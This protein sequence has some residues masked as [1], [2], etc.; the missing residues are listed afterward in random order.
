MKRQIRKVGVLGSGVMG[1]GIAGHLAG[2]GLE[3]VMLDIVPPKLSEEDEK[4]GITKD[5]PDFRNRFA[6]GALARALRENPQSGPLLHSDDAELIS[7]G[8]FEDHAFRL[9]EC[10]WIIEVVVEDLKIKRT[11]MKVV[12]KNWNKKAVVSTN[13]SGIPLREIAE[14][15]KP[16]LKKV[17]LG[18][19]FFNPVRFMHLLEIIPF[20]ETDRKVVEFMAGFCETRLG[21]GVVFGKD[22]PNFVANRIGVAGM[23]GTMNLMMEQGMKIDE[24]DQ[25]FG[26]PLG[27]P[28]SALF[29]TAD[30][31]GLD[32]LVHIAHNTTSYVK[33]EE[34]RKY[35]TLP[36]WVEGM[37]EKKYLGNKTGSGFYKRVDKKTFKV[38][39]PETLEYGD[40]SGEKFQSLALSGFIP[41]V[42]ER[43]K[44]VVNGEGREAEFAKKAV[45]DQLLYAAE[46]IP[47][48]ADRVVEVDNAMKWGF[49]FEVGPFEAWDALG[50]RESV[51]DMEEMGFKVPKK[52]KDMLSARAR[53]FYKDKKGKKLY[54]DF[55]KKDYVELEESGLVVNLAD[56][57]KDPKRVVDSR[58]TA[59]IVDIGDGVYCVEFHSV[60][61]ALDQDM[62]EMMRKAV[63]LAE[64]KGRGVVIGNQAPGMPGA[65]SAGANIAV[66]LEGARSK[67]WDTI[68]EAVRYFQE[69]NTYMTY[70]PVPVVAA[71]FGLTLGGGAEVAMSCNKIVCHHDLFMGLVEVG[72]G[73]IPGGGGCMLM[74]RHYQNFLPRNASINDLQPF[75]T[76]L[77]R[78][79]GTATV[80]NSAAHARDLGFLRPFDKIAFNRRHLIGLAKKEVLAMADLGFVPPRPQKYQVMG[81]QLRGVANA[82]VQDLV[83]GGYATEYDAFILRKLAHI[84]GG[85]FV[86]ENAWVPEEHLLELERE[87]FVELCAQE[88]TQARLEHM[89]KT[90][91]ALR[92]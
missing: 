55:K 17:F 46:R 83:L 51:A 40:P 16:E 10:D 15:V 30:M 38:I 66:I 43:I 31:V 29:R 36:K 54:Y 88:K 71:P 28:K 33:P 32:T 23:I 4:K 37:T 41:D 34:A 52:I 87:A 11:V 27:R 79:I 69:T 90:G 77:L 74:L 2:A 86:A 47:E 67:Q 49:N 45:Y 63:D 3:V 75:A 61:N 70:S 22:T 57:K 12:E 80:S 91:K 60:M 20:K 7:V 68:K 8:N 62:W 21:K 64:E 18:T 48:I 9:K 81:D 44:S 58:K 85:G 42:G 76:P 19:H 53:R 1:M 84:L 24:T 56:L 26:I 82:F 5:N 35:F 72:V 25:I 13:T 59:S 6:A 92:N 50:V 73:V 78:M 39:D 14:K 65:F 89:L